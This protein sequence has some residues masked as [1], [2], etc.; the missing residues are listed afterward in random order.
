MSLDDDGG[1][2]LVIETS[3]NQDNMLKSDQ[4][5]QIVRIDDIQRIEFN[6]FLAQYLSTTT[7][8]QQQQTIGNAAANVCSP[9]PYVTIN[10]SPSSMMGSSEFSGSGGEGSSSSSGGGYGGSG[11]GGFGGSGGG[12]GGRGGGGNKGGS[13]TS[14]AEIN[15]ILSSGSAIK[16]KKLE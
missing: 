2:F 15:K 13:E 11:G 16:V 7:Q 8:Q 10:V 6:D 4:L 9:S 14:S 12:G 5:K 1:G 3:D